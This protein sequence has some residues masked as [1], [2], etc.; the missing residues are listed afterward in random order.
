MK[1]LILTILFCTAFFSVNAQNPTYGVVRLAHGEMVDSIYRINAA[2]EKVESELKGRS[3]YTVVERNGEYYNMR[4]QITDSLNTVKWKLITQR[5]GLLSRFDAQM[6]LDV[7]LMNAG[8]Y[9]Q[10]ANSL[11]IIGAAFG[12]AG[13]TCM[14]AGFAQDKTA[15]KAAGIAACVVSFGCGIGALAC[16]YK[17]G[18][19]LKLAAGSITYSF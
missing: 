3:T 11:A 19:K 5:Q 13:G 4:D 6:G 9:I 1:H 7:H 12:I 2:I 10:R 17:A 15:L 16:G 14:G 18:N 8:K